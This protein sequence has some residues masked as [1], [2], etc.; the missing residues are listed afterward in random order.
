ML[1]NRSL[2]SARR[3]LV[4]LGVATVLVA[5]GGA[6]LAEV[7]SGTPAATPSFNGPVY[8]VAHRGD[9]VYVGGSFTGAIVGGKTI[10][11]PRLAA[12]DSRTGTLL[13]WNPGADGTVRALAID[14]ATV[15]AAG[16]F[17]RVAGMSRDA[18]AGIDATTGALGTLKHTVLGQP[19][20]LAVADGRLYVGGRITS[21][22]GSPRANLAA[23]ST[24][25]GALD[26]W[27]PT[28]DDTVNA[29]ATA[30]GRVYLGGSFHKT[31]NVRSTLRLTAVDGV[32]GVLDKSF[33]PKPVSQVFA[34]TTDAGGVYAALGGQGGRAIAY[35]FAGAARW[36][37]VFDGDAQAIATLN[38]TTYVGGHFDRACTTTN[39]GAQGLCTDGSV[40]RVKLA[41]ID[42]AGNL[43]EWGP[44]A[45]GVVGVRTLAANPATGLLSVGG[46]FTT[47]GGVTQKRYASFGGPTSR[48]SV[49]PAPPSPYVAS[50]NFDSTVPDGTYDDG[51]GNG[52]LLRTLAVNGGELTTVA[53]GNGQAIVFPPK[54]TGTTCPRVVLQATDAPDLNPGSKNLRYGAHVLLSP[55]ETSTGENILQKGY[56]TAGGQYKLQ[57]DGV[58]GKPSCVMSDKDATA[59]YV[60]KSGKSM[61]DGSWHTIECRRAG[62]TLT[63][64]VDDKAEGSATLPAGLSVVTTQPLSLGGKGTGVNNDQF[65]GSL[66]DAWVSIG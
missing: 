65:H 1:N 42:G 62:T 45:N 11:R 23:F 25:T 30:G 5:V 66:D 37:R 53:H 57:I 38:G 50:Y 15:Y 58:S 39:N 55:A 14:G 21:V 64:L 61:A 7:V 59:I 3:K 10:A 36:T 16:D 6:A 18:V 28:T 54:C 12:F 22:D 32:T 43:T 9:V 29:L 2:T 33:V 44:Q 63:I 31:N 56:S 34:L 52:H 51:S 24:A 41:A 40:P 4:T 19:N 17:D 8:A 27:A 46:D 13:G 20:A 60:A 49:P 26:A 48:Q 47:V 35:T